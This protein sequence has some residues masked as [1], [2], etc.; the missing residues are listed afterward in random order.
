MGEAWQASRNKRRNGQGRS[1]SFRPW[2][3]CPKQCGA[4]LYRDQL[5]SEVF[6][7]RCGAHYAKSLAIIPANKKH[8]EGQANGAA[9]SKAVAAPPLALAD[10]AGSTPAVSPELLGILKTASNNVHGMLTE[11]QQAEPPSD[12]S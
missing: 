11:P 2:A 8:N 1:E 3:P 10:A 12:D 4:W 7:C 5:I 9:G 6:K